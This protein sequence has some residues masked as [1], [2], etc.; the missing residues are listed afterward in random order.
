MREIC[1]IPGEIAKVPTGIGLAIVTPRLL[2]YSK[3]KNGFIMA[4]LLALERLLRISN[5]A[6]RR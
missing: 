6:K 3:R 2:S 1:T 5:P 4:E